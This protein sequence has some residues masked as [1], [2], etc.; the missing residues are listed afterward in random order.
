ME[1]RQ[2]GY[3]GLR[4]KKSEHA[5]HTSDGIPFVEQQDL[6]RFR[7]EVKIP[8]VDSR[9]LVGADMMMGRKFENREVISKVDFDHYFNGVKADKLGGRSR[10]LFATYILNNTKFK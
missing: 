4:R 2:P 3:T 9:D 8:G 6:E 5:M 7:R 1:S 10:Y